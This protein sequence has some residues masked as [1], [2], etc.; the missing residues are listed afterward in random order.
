MK[1]TWRH[2]QIHLCFPN[3]QI[4]EAKHLL[5]V[6][7]AKAQALQGNGLTAS[8][9]SAW[10]NKSVLT[11]PIC[12]ISTHERSCNKFTQHP[13]AA[14]NKLCDIG[15][16]GEMIHFP[17]IRCCKII[18]L[19]TDD[20]RNQPSHRLGSATASFSRSQKKKAV[21]ADLC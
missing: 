16:F 18:A 4:F 7:A 13:S 20:S 3:S 8:K 12:Q 21:L 10:C 17:P 2:Q 14:P 1:T 5:L 9:T 19:P 6:S 11:Q 15:L